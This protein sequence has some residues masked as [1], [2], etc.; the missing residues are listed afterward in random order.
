MSINET[1]AFEK[2]N[3]HLWLTT[4]RK[5]EKKGGNILNWFENI[6]EK[7]IDNTVLTGE[8][9]NTFLLGSRTREGYLIWLLLLSRLLEAPANEIR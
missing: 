8:S 1:K 3:I 9:P 6:C 2:F 7:P 4:L 5:L